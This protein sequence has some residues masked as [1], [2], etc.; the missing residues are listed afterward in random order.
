MLHHNHGN[1]WA[2]YG[3]DHACYARAGFIN[4]LVK[5]ACNEPL[6]TSSYGISLADERAAL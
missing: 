1:N 3:Y 4:S 2:T 6:T 5:F